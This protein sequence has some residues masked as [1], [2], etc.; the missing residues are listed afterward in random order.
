MDGVALRHVTDDDVPVFFDQQ[1]DAAA[2]YMAAFTMNESGDRAAFTA[3]WSKIMSD[4]SIARRTVLSDGR[5]A[6]HVLSFIHGGDREV[7]YWIGRDYWGRGIATAAL[8]AFLRILRSRPL[9][10][11]AAKD[12]IASLRVLEKCGFEICGEDRG[13]ANARRAEVEELILRL[14]LRGPVA[15]PSAESCHT[16][17]DSRSV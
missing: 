3:H 12:N 13:F 14:D 9:Y 17:S 7:S 15:G 2:S 11:R 10:A 4:E 8:S 16:R 1:L 6:G 5:V